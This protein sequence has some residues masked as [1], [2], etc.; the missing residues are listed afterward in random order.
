[1]KIEQEPKFQPIT[2]TL[3]TREEAEI[4]WDYALLY[5]AKPTERCDE[6]EEMA[7]KFSNWFIN[8]GQI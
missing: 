4:F 7:K 5:E 2:I 8:N 1:M 3:E 6:V